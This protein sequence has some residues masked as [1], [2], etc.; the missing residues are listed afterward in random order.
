MRNYLLLVVG[1]IAHFASAATFYS[2]PGQ[3]NPN[4]LTNW[5]TN[6]DGT[7]FTPFNFRGG[8]IFVIQTG[9]HYITTDNWTVNGV[10]GI[11]SVA[12][13]ELTA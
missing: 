4:L 10:N 13:I 11:L 2:K 5:T 1:I 3:T 6:P 8:D 9:H 7:G 12:G